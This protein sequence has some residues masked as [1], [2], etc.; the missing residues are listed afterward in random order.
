VS[1][2]RE[3]TKGFKVIFIVRII[4][5]FNPTKKVLYGIAIQTTI[6]RF[7]YITVLNGILTST[8]RPP[9]V[10]Q[11]IGWLIDQYSMNWFI[12]DNSQLVPGSATYVVVASVI[13][14]Q[15]RVMA[16]YHVW[17]ARVQFPVRSML[18]SVHSCW[19]PFIVAICTFLSCKCAGG[20]QWQ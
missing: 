12:M 8:N 14:I 16:T 15:S 10:M 5:Q 4:V 7:F 6:F 11:L 18:L 9:I 17:F 19:A 3:K 1:F 20:Q 13:E 2:L